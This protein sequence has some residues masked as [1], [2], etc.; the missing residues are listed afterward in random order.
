M[1]EFPMCFTELRIRHVG[2]DLRR[3]DRGMPEKL[4]DD[5][6]IGTI[7]EESCREAMTEGMR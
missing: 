2:I 7:R 5:T 4:L 3:R 1:V 6:H